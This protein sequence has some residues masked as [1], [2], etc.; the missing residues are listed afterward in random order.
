LAA[1]RRAVENNRRL[2]LT[3]FLPVGRHPSVVVEAVAKH[4]TE[5]RAD[6]EGALR[7]RG[8]VSE[9][10]TDA[11]LGTQRRRVPL[12][13]IELGESPGQIEHLIANCV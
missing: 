13:V 11:P 12:L 10:V 1:F 4:S 5:D 6:S 9:H 3:T 2:L 7:S 8:D